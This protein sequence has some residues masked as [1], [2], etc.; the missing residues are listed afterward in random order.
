ML[1]GVSD[2]S[3]GG[4]SD[5]SRKSG[6]GFWSTLFGSK[7][8]DSD[9]KVQSKNSDNSVVRGHVYG[10]TENGG[11]THS[12]YSLDK[13]SGSYKEYHGGENSSD[14]SFNKR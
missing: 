11:H 14:R 1:Y 7:G 9:V 10:H 2:H 13:T 5:S 3:G 12:S 6:G 4:D 8:E